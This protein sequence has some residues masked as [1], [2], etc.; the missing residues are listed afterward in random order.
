MVL[1]CVDN[2]YDYETC[3]CLAIQCDAVGCLYRFDAKVS[4]AVKMVYS[5]I[6]K[7]DATP[8]RTPREI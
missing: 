4:M 8:P 2:V 5:N 3:I 6:G 1:T 7:G